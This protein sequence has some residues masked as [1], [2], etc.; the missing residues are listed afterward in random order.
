[1]WITLLEEYVMIKLEISHSLPGQSGSSGVLSLVLLL[2]VAVMASPAALAHH[3]PGHGS[4]GGGGNTGGGGKDGPT[5]YTVAVTKHHDILPA[6]L[7]HPSDLKPLCL[8]EAVTTNYNARFP[9]WD[10][11]AVLTTTLEPYQ[12]TNNV[13]IRVDNTNGVLTNVY[14]VGSDG[15]T[16]GDKANRV[17]RSDDISL[18]GAFIDIDRENGNFVIHVHAEGVPVKKCNGSS[19]KPKTKCNEYAG[20]VAI[21]D[22]V[23]MVEN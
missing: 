13:V 3:A 21:D 10:P 8:A 1:L 17:Y 16:P 6:G 4:G 11:C 7:Y 20:T 14:V 2:A 15:D 22:M 9:R 23:Y 19:L 12:L 18:V 5:E